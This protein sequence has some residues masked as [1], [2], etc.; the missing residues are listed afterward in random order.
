MF[1]RMAIVASQPFSRGAKSI[2]FNLKSAVERVRD[3]Q[4]LVRKRGAKRRRI[5]LVDLWRRAKPPFSPGSCE[6]RIRAIAVLRFNQM[7]NSISLDRSSGLSYRRRGIF[8][9]LATMARRTL[10]GAAVA[11]CI[12]HTLLADAPLNDTFPGESVLVDSTNTVTSSNLGA[13]SERGEPN[14]AGN[15]AAASVWWTW[16]APDSGL[17]VVDTRGS[18]FD[19]VLAVYVGD[20]VSG[21]TLIDSNDDEAGLATSLVH[22]PAIGGTTYRIAVDG[23]QGASG[24]IQLSIR[25]PVVPAPPAILKQPISQAVLENA[26]SNVTFTAAVTGSFPRSFQWQKDEAPLVAGTNASYMVSNAILTDAGG[27]RVIITN[28]FGSVT[29]SVAV[30]TVHSGVAQDS[31]AGRIPISGTALAETAHNFGATLEAGEPIH[32]GVSNGASIWWSWTASQNGLVGLDTAGST[33]SLGEVLDT[34]LAVYDGRIVSGLSAIAS[35]NDESPG[36][37]KSSKLF[38]RA[39]AG[40]TYQIA[41]AGVLDTNGTVAIGEIKLHLAQSPDNDY[42]A[43]ALAFPQNVTTV[44]DDNRGTSVEPGEPPHAGNP[45]GSSVWWYWVAPSEGTYVLDTVGSSI[46]TVLAVYSGTSVSA[47]TLIGEDDNRGDD[48]ASLVKFF[49]KNGATYRFA[50]DGY[51]GPNGVAAGRIILNL[52][53]STGL[54]DNF[55]DRI[56]LSGQT[57]QVTASNVG[58]SKQTGEPAHGGN[59]GGRSVWWSW[60]AHITAPVLISTRNSSFDTVLAV[61]TGTQLSSLGLVAENDDADPSDPIGGSTVFFMATAG[62]TYQIAVDGYRSSDGSVP[63]GAIVLRLLQGTPPALGGNDTFANRFQITGQSATLIG[64]NTNASEES[65]EPNHAGNDGGRSIWWSWTAPAS[66]PVKIDTLGSSFNTLLGVYQGSSV[67][68]L[69]LVASDQDSAEGDLSVVTF[70]AVQGVE[71]QIA[72]DGFNDGLGADIGLVVLH[73]NQFAAGALNADDDFLNSSPISA[74]FLTVAGLNIGATREPGE[75]LHAAAPQGHSVWWTWTAPT[76]GSVTISTTGSEFDTVLGVYTGNEVGSL[77]LVAENDDI[78]A[79]DLQSSVTFQAVAETSYR[80]AVDGYGNEIGGI[81]LTVAPGADLASAPQ[82]EQAPLDQTRFSGGGGGGANVSFRVVA[83]G[84]LPLSFQWLHDGQVL[85]DST[86]DV[87]TLTNAGAPDVGA[88]QVVVSNRFGTV[89]S[90]EARFSL[91]EMPFND[92]FSSRI[93]ITGS[94]NIVNG[95]VVGASKQAHEPHHGGEVGGRSVWWRWVAP[96]D[97]S[98]AINTLGSSFDTLLAVYQGSDVGTLTLVAENNDLVPDRVSASRVLFNAVA[99]QEYQIAVDSR[100]TNGTTGNVLLT[101]RQPPLVDGAK[102]V[103]ALSA[104]SSPLTREGPVTFSVNYSDFNFDKSTL[105]PADVTLNKSGTANGSIAVSGSGTRW[106]V[107]IFGITGDGALGISIAA[108]TGTDTV[109]NSADAVGPSGAFEVDN[110]KPTV[111]ISEP[112]ASVTHGEAVTFTAHYADLNFQTITLAPTDIQLNRTGSANGTVAVVNSGATATVTISK[113]TGEGTLGISL[114]VG[115]A[116][117]KAGNSANAA[118]PSATFSVIDST[119]PPIPD[120]PDLIGDDDTGLSRIDD[121]T[122]A[123]L[124]TFVGVGE[125]GTTLTLK[126]G[127]TVLGGAEVVAGAWSLTLTNPL[128]GTHNLTAFLT[129]PKGNASADSDSLILIVDRTAP[130]ISAIS[131]Q[132][133]KQ[134]EIVNVTFNVADTQAAASDLSVQAVSSN[135]SLIANANLILSGTGPSRALKVTPTPNL[136]GDADII[137]TVTDVAGNATSSSFHV[138]VQSLN[139]V[140]TL[141]AIPDQNVL[142]ASG[143]HVLTLTGISSGLGENQ[144]LTIRALSDNVGIVNHPITV[145]TLPAGTAA[146]VF[147]P[148]GHANG[149]VTISVIISDDGGS[150]GGGV[151]SVTN[152]FNV[153]VQSINLS[154]FVQSSLVDRSGVYGSFLNFTLPANSFGDPDS[155]DVLNYTATGAPAGVAF[156]PQTKTFSGTPRVAGSFVITVTARDNGGLS[157]ANSFQLTVGKAPLTVTADNKSK[158]YGAA[159]PALTA[160]YTGFAAGDTEANLLSPVLLSTPATSSSVVG[161]YAIAA[162]G[163]TSPNYEI[164]FL[165]GTLTITRASLRIAAANASS[166]YGNSISVLT[167]VFTG[168]V[169]DDT[170]ASLD[171]PVTLS[172]QATASS[173]VGVYPIKVAGGDDANYTVE[174]VDGLLTITAA[175]LTVHADDLSRAYRGANPV[176]SG[177]ITGLKNGESLSV[178]YATEATLQSAVG[179]YP[180]VPTVTDPNGV[181]SQ[182][183]LALVPGLLTVLD[184][185]DVGGIVFDGYIAGGTLFFD[186]NNNRKLDPDEPFTVTDQDGRFSF[187]FSIIDFDVNHNNKLD[188]SEGVLVLTGGVDISSGL[189]LQGFLSAP[190]GASVVTPLTTLIAT[191]LELNPGQTMEVAQTRIKAGLG[192]PETVDLNQYDPFAAF[193]TNDVSALNILS[194]GAKVQDTAVLITALLAP[195]SD[196]IGVEVFHRIIQSILQQISSV[197]PNLS[198]SAVVRKVIDANATNSVLE[199]GLVEDAAAAIA[200]NNAAID[201]IIAAGLTPG[202]AALEIGRLQGVAQRDLAAAFAEAAAP[203]TSASDALAILHQALANIATRTSPVGVSSGGDLR[204]G[205]FLF[206]T[207]TYEASLLGT[208]SAKITVIRTDGSYGPGSVELKIGNSNN[209]APLLL[210]FGSREISRTVDILPLIIGDTEF[211]KAGFINLSLQPAV[212]SGTNPPALGPVTTAV[213]LIRTL[214]TITAPDDA[215]AALGG[216]ATF[217]VTVTGSP[218]PAL[219]WTKNGVAL[220]GQTNS[221]LT[222]IDLKPEDAGLYQLTASNLVGIAVSSPASLVL[223]FPPIISGN[224]TTNSVVQGT[225]DIL[226]FAVQG[227][228]PI[229]YQ[230]RKSGFNITGQTNA[231]LNLGAVLLTDSGQYTLFVKNAY[232]SATSPIITLVVKDPEELH[233]QFLAI[234]RRPDGNVDLTMNLPLG[235]HYLLEQST[236]LKNWTSVTEITP[237]TIPHE[238]S[239]VVTP[240][241]N[242]LFFRATATQ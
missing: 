166:S 99:G 5:F 38:F 164:N 78:D 155:E 221:V 90:A 48:G 77:S 53:S 181:L 157:A 6:D 76:D 159:L 147:A 217:S 24:S 205:L 156:D 216:Q 239:V 153:T 35:N 125:T 171:V 128:P 219:Q 234:H 52:N 228:S 163:G 176:L 95:S 61:Y 114:G 11:G 112:S 215:V 129:D 213:L 139:A 54:N 214:P 73:L 168:L 116:L 235:H 182:Y 198:L 37:I 193:L 122:K 201:A 88:Y 84:S 149:R 144:S 194:A 2:D 57:N 104:P 117:D 233:F 170:S 18:A 208:G 120:K 187:N 109:G 55:G 161:T 36:L 226:S 189:P 230:W 134:N 49:A 169:A 83:T 56:T 183:N 26:G 44:Y 81:T 154:P 184:T 167:P 207:Q 241:Q 46:D 103:V 191:A 12:S 59:P 32:A 175:P 158:I 27:Y 50:V 34:V 85:A 100:K 93:L 105:T 111:V 45:G 9:R 190:V 178:T 82:V 16:I 224:P 67:G 138:T 132:S 21:L 86:N 203:T 1:T 130:T 63:E 148:V 108:G 186:A 229:Q 87:L 209:I 197:A 188:S 218:E 165:P 4:K 68:A 177:T 223:N 123:S 196:Q 101:L 127:V 13:S 141:N 174:R 179:T 17:A 102:P 222:L 212:Q 66:T 31:F 113:I 72:V 143:E 238:Q 64:S 172:S 210:E 10:L 79:F 211:T 225:M 126:E 110:T 91:V 115:T 151:K 195:S 43:N 62:Q 15:P 240:P 131:N 60:T 107:K 206:D 202:K 19:T 29:S 98:V 65:G 150:D 58:A 135:L 47:L 227:T 74:P 121:I 118:G 25:L 124:L 39:I 92:D 185:V 106:T 7:T 14:H 33:N 242:Q 75:P 41:V 71:Y 145:L 42:F 192:I 28:S 152:K 204:P 80:I 220:P 160:A 200:S 237:Q 231:T 140:P 23:Y 70:E 180:I 199:T 97:G 51:S 20:F 133:V 69:A 162:S 173:K 137:L 236:D 94:S 30:L 8:S 142:E 146:L 96:E 232:G 136:S 40:V 22:F 89:T 3:L 119:A